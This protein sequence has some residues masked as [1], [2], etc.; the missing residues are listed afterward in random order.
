MCI[1]ARYHSCL[2]DRPNS[3]LL[4]KPILI[5]RNSP[6]SEIIGLVVLWKWITQVIWVLDYQKTLETLPH[7]RAQDRRKFRCL[8]NQV[9]AKSRKQRCQVSTTRTYPLLGPR[10]RK[11]Q[12]NWRIKSLHRKVEEPSQRF[13]KAPLKFHSKNRIFEDKT[14]LIN[15]FTFKQFFEFLLI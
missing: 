2:V 10:S 12:F 9:G 8:A 14:F 15:L 11:C 5:R 6:L 4:L 7:S 1:L 3:S 13:Q